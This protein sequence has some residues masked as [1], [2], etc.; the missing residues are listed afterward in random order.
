[1]TDAEGG[2]MPTHDA[3]DLLKEQVWQ[4]TL[5]LERVENELKEE[6]RLL[7]KEVDVLKGFHANYGY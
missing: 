5:R 1:M 4:L 2:M 3:Y 6:I 7:Q